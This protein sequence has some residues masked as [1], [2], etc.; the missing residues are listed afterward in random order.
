MYTVQPAS[1]RQQNF[2]FCPKNQTLARKNHAPYDMH[3]KSFLSFSPNSYTGIAK[4]CLYRQCM[5]KK[6][7]NQSIN[8]SKEGPTNQLENQSINQSKEGPTNQLEN[9]SINQSIEGAHQTLCI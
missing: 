3:S 8:Q 7:T 1:N 4:S 6:P 5:L 9:Q 2:T